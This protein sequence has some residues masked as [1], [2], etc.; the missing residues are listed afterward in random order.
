[1]NPVRCPDPES[2]EAMLLEIK[3][4]RERGDSIGGK[5]R[6]IA[7]NPP[8]GIGEPVF[9]TLEGDLA[10]A[11]F[12]IPAVKAV[13]FGAGTG[14]AEMR[15]SE[16]NDQYIIKDGEIKTITNNCGGILGG[17]SNGMPIMAT[18]TFKPTPSISMK[19]QTVNM[20]TGK[21]TVLQVDGRHDP[22]IVPR[23]VP[24]VE[25]MMAIVLADL[26]I[27]SGKIPRILGN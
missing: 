13:E 9:D 12:S 15:G 8:K 24:V 20:N 17:I 22:C 2:A 18:I 4:T 16:S 1:L 19:Q 5:V 21:E 7:I 10:K 11:F 3:N 26:S 23:A 14:F 6:C 25:A 27:Y